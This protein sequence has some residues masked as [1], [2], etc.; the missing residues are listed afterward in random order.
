M[1]TGRETL[2]ELKVE[3]DFK[4]FT[5]NIESTIL[6]MQSIP[7]IQDYQYFMNVYQESIEL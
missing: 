2:G 5:L 4:S 3:L 6:P 7:A 1:I